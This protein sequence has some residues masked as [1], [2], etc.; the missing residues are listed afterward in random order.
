MN[1]KVFYKK[2]IK[3][4]I[5]TIS[6][7]ILIVILYPILTGLKTDNELFMWVFLTI[8]G[9]FG[10]YQ[11][12]REQSTIATCPH[13]SIDLFEIIQTAK[14]TKMQMKYCPSC[15]NQVDI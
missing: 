8:A 15:G 13:C 6:I 11:L 12:L 9:S 7:V 3:K 14:V 4:Q 2:A 1:T 10:T 5:L